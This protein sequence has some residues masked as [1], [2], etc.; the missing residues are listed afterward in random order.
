MMKLVFLFL[1]LLLFS[2]GA[3]ALNC[4]IYLRSPEEMA[5]YRAINKRL[6]DKYPVLKSVMKDPEE[7]ILTTRAKFEAQKLLTPDNPYGFDYSELGMP[8][9]E[10]MNTEITEK[11]VNFKARVAELEAKTGVWAYLTTPFRAKKIKEYEIAMQYLDDVQRE[12]QGYLMAGKVD[13]KNLYE[14]SYF[15]SRAI[16]HFDLKLLNVRDRLL[17]Y[18][19]RYLQGYKQLKIE[20]EY[21][22]F[23]QR[24]FSVFQKES[25]VDGFQQASKTFE[26]AFMNQDKLEMIILPTTEE[27]GP[28]IFSRL[29]SYDVFPISMTSKPVAADGFVRPGGDFWMHD[30][31]HS[32]AIFATRKDYNTMYNLG[33]NQVTELRAKSEIWKTELD[34]ARKKIE[35]KELRYAIGFFMFNFHHDRGYPMLPSSYVDD[36]LDHVPYLLYY[37]LKASKQPL[38]FKNP[39]ATMNKAYAWL[40]D[41]W[42]QRLEEEKAILNKTLL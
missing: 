28:D 30:I 32:S 3:L 20:K 31:R 23:Q 15:Y 27:L 4:D 36:H 38:G 42:L 33:L 29:V 14:I 22:L 5:A 41:F 11:V 39:Q 12:I 19:D 18:I 34:T 7:F 6:A 10:S 8:A 35:D 24:S 1:S 2:F 40:Q 21:A 25:P 37:T 13:Y 9:L 16:G 17:L 26:D